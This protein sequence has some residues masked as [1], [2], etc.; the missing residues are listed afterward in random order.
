MNAVA[1][2]ISEEGVPITVFDVNHGPTS[3][4]ILPSLWTHQGV[5]VGAPTYEGALFPPMA[6]VLRMAAQ[7]RHQDKRVARF[8][9]YGWSGGA[10]RDFE[11][12][13]DP[14]KWELSELL[15]FAGGPTE[16]DLEQGEAFGSRFARLIKGG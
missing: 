10:Q 3:S 8:G 12:L 6:Q 1:Q 4:Y 16:E 9:S 14:I 2:G 5:M 11:R 13:I 7:K 15:E